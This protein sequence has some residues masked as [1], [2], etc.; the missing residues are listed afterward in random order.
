[1]GAGNLA[2]RLKE[3]CF[4]VIPFE[5]GA[6]GYSPMRPVSRALN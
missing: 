6:V 4:S 3:I 2:V 1:M 5:E